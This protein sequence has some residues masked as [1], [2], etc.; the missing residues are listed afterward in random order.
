MSWIF[1]RAK[2]LRTLLSDPAARA[3]ITA[4]IFT[5]P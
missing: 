1:S 5:K 4:E 3:R 2:N